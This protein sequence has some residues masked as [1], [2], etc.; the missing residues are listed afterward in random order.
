MDIH[1][2]SSGFEHS[3]RVVM[4][5]T[6]LNYSVSCCYRDGHLELSGRSW[7]NSEALLWAGFPGEACLSAVL[8]IHETQT[9][10]MVA[11]HGGDSGVSMDLAALVAWPLYGPLQLVANAS[12]AVPALQ[13]LGLPFSNQMLK[14]YLL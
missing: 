5:P 4:G 10:A 11:F 8:Q 3:G 13:R 9:Q 2:G 12:H 1:N 7:H 6:F 14:K